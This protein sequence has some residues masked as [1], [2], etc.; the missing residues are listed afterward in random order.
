VVRPDGSATAG[1][2]ARS[3]CGSE[4]YLMAGSYCNTITETTE[5]GGKP[6]MAEEDERKQLVDRHE[7]WTVGRERAQDTTDQWTALGDALARRIS[8]L[9]KMA[10]SLPAASNDEWPEQVWPETGVDYN[11]VGN[12]LRRAMDGA[13]ALAGAYG[14]AARDLDAALRREPLPDSPEIARAEQ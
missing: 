9:W 5:P 13:Y 3:P 1:P 8:D 14:R 12:H 7:V 10:P 11:A 2:D 4:R 6:D